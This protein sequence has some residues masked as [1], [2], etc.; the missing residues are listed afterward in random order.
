M[1]RFA[2]TLVFIAAC[3]GLAYYVLTHPGLERVERLQNKYESLKNKNE[4]LADKNERLREKIVALREDPRLAER[5]ARERARLAR[6]DELV[7]QF[8]SDDTANRPMRV[9]L[10]VRA[11]ELELAGESVGIDGLASALEE[12]HRELPEAQLTVTFADDV[13]PLRKERIIDLVD[14]SKLAPAK[15]RGTGK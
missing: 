4:R 11:D 10:D 2:I 6:P 9:E 13:G 15:Y 14:H 3:S 12:M 5:R 7:L 8:G 1:K